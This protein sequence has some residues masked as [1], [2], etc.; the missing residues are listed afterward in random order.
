[1]AG[2]EKLRIFAK[3]FD[4]Y[5]ETETGQ[6]VRRPETASAEAREAAAVRAAVRV[7]GV[8]QDAVRGAE[9]VRHAVG[10]GA[11]LPDRA[12]AAAVGRADAGRAAGVA[13]RGVVGDG[14][15]V[16]RKA[17]AELQRPRRAGVL[18]DGDERR[19]FPPDVPDADG[20]RPD[21]LHADDAGRG[22]VAER[23]RLAAESQPVV[24][25]RVRHA[26]RRAP[27]PATQEGRCG[28][29]PAVGRI[30]A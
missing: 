18:P 12:G 24:P 3:F 28:A 19:G 1:M 14:G 26:A 10:R 13:R 17:R 8:V 25:P 20:G 21:A 9:G 11:V 30:M 4:D 5:E 15:A 16:L 23:H 2:R 22:G 27:P 7:G 29:L 6:M